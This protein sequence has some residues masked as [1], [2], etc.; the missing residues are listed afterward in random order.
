[1][2][3]SRQQQTFDDL[4][5]RIFKD[6]ENDYTAKLFLPDATRVSVSLPSLPEDLSLA[7][8]SFAYGSKL[9]SWL[10]QGELLEAF[11]YVQTLAEQP[12]RSYKSSSSSGL[13][14]RLWLDPKASELH[15]LRWE[16]LYEPG[17]DEP[18]SL[19]S[20]FS[21][22][23]RSPAPRGWGISDRP[24]RML[25]IASNPSGL[26]QFD[27]STIDVDLENRIVKEATHPLGPLLE[28]HKLTGFTTLD[29]IQSE[30]KRGYH[31]TH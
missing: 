13:R 14:I 7:S 10:F 26:D 8:D 18:L 24:L 27:L 4:E 23:V 20:A 9:F 19:R 21:R 11:N 30:E 25:L 17:N 12:T 22:F 28:L 15:S 3:I 16:S 6:Y 31:I 5:I 1:M 29:Q 2:E